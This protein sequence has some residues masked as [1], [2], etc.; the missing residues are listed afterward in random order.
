MSTMTTTVRALT[1]VCEHTLGEQ[2]VDQTLEQTETE[3]VNGEEND[4]G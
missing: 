1:I 4:F 3:G 2:W